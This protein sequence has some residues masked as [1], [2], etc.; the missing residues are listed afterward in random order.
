MTVVCQVRDDK[1][2]CHDVEHRIGERQTR[3]PR[4]G[5]PVRSRGSREAEHRHRGIDADHDAGR[6][7]LGARLKGDSPGTRADIKYASPVWQPEQPNEVARWRPKLER[8]RH[9]VVRRRDVRIGVRRIIPA[10][11]ARRATRVEARHLDVCDHTSSSA[12]LRDC[13]RHRFARQC[14]VDEDSMNSS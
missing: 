3:D 6:P 12:G 10:W 7:H 8:C 11:S 1:A 9:A 13:R 2:R 14:A 5:D 4:E